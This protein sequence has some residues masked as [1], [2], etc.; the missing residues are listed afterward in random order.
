MERE[1]A[2]KPRKWDPFVLLLIDVQRDFLTKEISKAFPD[3]EKNV[4]GLLD[5]CR[6]ERLD[7]VHMRAGFRPDK[8][9]WMAKYKLLDRTPCVAGTPGAEVCA[10]A[11]ELPG[12]EV[13]TKQTFD[14]FHNPVLYSYLL[15]NKKRFVLV[16][17][18][19]T[20][21]CL[22]LTAA[23]AAQRGYLV[24]MV[25]DC[26]ADEPEAHRH[27]LERYPFIFSR[28]TAEQIPAN[29]QKWLAE[30]NELTND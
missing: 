8:S 22:L 21:V 15:E 28:T 12:E 11:K 30:L 6:Q 27:T 29:R 20:S 10:F 9:D 19:I 3:Y 17:G 16:A 5:F 14:G 26:C 25:E 24:G 1:M 23:N 18:L 2:D 4:S 7:V 13:I